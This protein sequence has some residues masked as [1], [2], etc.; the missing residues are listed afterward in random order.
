[1]EAGD[2]WARLEQLVRQV[3][4]EEL[5]KLTARIEEAVSS[6]KEKVDFVNGVFVIPKMHRASLEAA[7]GSI[8]LDD[9]IRRAAAY[10]TTN[11]HKAPKSQYGRFLNA[12]LARSQDRAALKLIPPREEIKRR[13]CGYCSLN[14]I[15]S[16]NGIQHCRAH[17][18]DAYEGK[19]RRMLGV[20]PKPV[21][22][23]D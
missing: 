8:D 22:G 19:Q 13:A 21:A 4:R 17:Y 20:V 1:V 10:I 3:L 23:N 2:K 5:E 6:K 15:G 12:W 9:E 18:Q 14:S 16:V 11:P 7:Y